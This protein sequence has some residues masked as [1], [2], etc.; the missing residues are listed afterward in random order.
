MR[1]YDIF[2]SRKLSKNS[3]LMELKS[4][5]HHLIDKSLLIIDR[6]SVDEIPKGEWLFFYSKNGVKYFLENVEKLGVD[7]HGYKIGCVGRKTAEYAKSR[8]LHVDFTGMGSGKSSASAFVKKLH[9]GD[10]II[11]PCALHSLHTLSPYLPKTVKDITLP[12]Y[13]N[14][15]EVNPTIPE[16]DIAVLTSPLNASTF[17]RHYEGATAPV[18]VSIGHTTGKTITSMTQSRP[19]IA[20]QSSEESILTVIDS[21]ISKD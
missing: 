18:Y 21:I 2:V 19:V 6:L 17:I 4:R 8:H 14:A 20:P 10:T 15:P 7:I 9:A 11:F 1:S 13:S 12:V 3:P 5:G 16:V